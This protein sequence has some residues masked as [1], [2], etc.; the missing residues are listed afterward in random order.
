MPSCVRCGGS[1]WARYDYN[2]LTGCSA[3][4]AHPAGKRYVQSKYHP[5]P[6]VETCGHCGKEF[7]H[8]EGRDA[9]D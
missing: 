3:C 2:H 7:Q 4:C 8:E 6:G 9:A 5:N 1:G